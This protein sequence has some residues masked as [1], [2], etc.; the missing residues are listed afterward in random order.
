[1]TLSDRYFGCF[2]ASVQGVMEEMA[3]DKEMKAPDPS[4]IVAMLK[5]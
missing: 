5:K 4:W 1:M 2:W 3:M